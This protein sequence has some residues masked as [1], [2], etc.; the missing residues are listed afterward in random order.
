MSPWEIT[1][2]EA[3]ELIKEIETAVIKAKQT[4]AA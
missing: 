3:E 2:E 1:I 4:N